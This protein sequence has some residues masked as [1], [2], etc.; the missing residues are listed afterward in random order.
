M[1]SG[2][3]TLIN[4]RRKAGPPTATLLHPSSYQVIAQLR[5]EK[6]NDGV[7]D[8][9]ACLPKEFD[10]V[11]RRGRWRANING[12]RKTENCRKIIRQVQETV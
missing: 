5:H 2:V 8:E 4:W 11:C 3:A 7:L 12:N 1:S 6:L 9:E 10:K